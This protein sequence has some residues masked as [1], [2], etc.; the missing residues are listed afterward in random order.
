MEF[1][2]YTYLLFLAFAVVVVRP[3]RN[4]IVRD[5]ALL[6]LSLIFYATWD[7][8]YLG[9]LLGIGIFTYLSGHWVARSRGHLRVLMVPVIAILLTLSVFKYTG[10]L[11]ETVNMLLPS[12]AR[13]TVPSI[14]LPLGISFFTFECISYLLDV[15]KGAT[16]LTPLRRFLLFPAFWPHMVA[17]PI[18]RLKEFAPQLDT[19]RRA[20]GPEI[21]Q[22]ID[23]ILFGWV[24]KLVFA[25][26]LAS[27][28]D[29]GFAGGVEL[30]HRQLGPRRRFRPA[31]LFRFFRLQRHC[32]RFCAP[33]RYRL[34]GELRP[35]IPCQ[36]PLGV[37]DAMAHDALALDT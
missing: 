29:Q 19:I 20:T 10:L 24:K 31:D 21:L 6:S 9:V 22:A 23:R 37:L 28:V 7:V 1:T 5:Y 27:V 17:G 32:N 11:A 33:T 30:E 36:E 15:Y 35:P 34:S 12:T 25:N 13:L 18:L 3:L 2:S 8:R 4:L 16:E 14:V 26:S